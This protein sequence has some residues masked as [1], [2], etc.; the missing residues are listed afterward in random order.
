[1]PSLNIFL[2]KLQLM[3]SSTVLNEEFRLTFSPDHNFSLE[4][5]TE[6][7]FSMKTTF[8]QEMQLTKTASDVGDDLGLYLQWIE[9]QGVF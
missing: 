9:K 7:I 5:L 2:Q 1:M 8:R 4:K 3:T 6:V